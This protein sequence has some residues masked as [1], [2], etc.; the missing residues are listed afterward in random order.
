[1]GQTNEWMD[2]FKLHDDLKN[3]I[4]QKIYCSFTF[5]FQLHYSRGGNFTMNSAKRCLFFQ[6]HRTAAQSA[7]QPFLALRDDTK[8]G[9]VADS[10]QP[11]E[12]LFR[13]LVESSFFLH[14]PSA[15]AGNLLQLC[16]PIQQKPGYLE[17][18]E[19]SVFMSFDYAVSISFR[20]II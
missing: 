5:S 16:L 20:T 13:F 18:R 1:M 14:T 12:C 11:G 19:M 15:C 9:C 8:N 6:S 10:L 3:E 7:T 17:F 2:W 4:I